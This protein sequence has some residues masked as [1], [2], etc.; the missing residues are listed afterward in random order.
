LRQDVRRAV[1]AVRD[2]KQ[3]LV[4][5]FADEAFIIFEE[6]LT[7]PEMTPD[8]VH[9]VGC[10]G[11]NS[12][13]AHLTSFSIGSMTPAQASLIPSRCRLLFISSACS[14]G[15]QTVTPTRG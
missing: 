13:L 4:N 3:R 15:G 6:C 12:G 1:S 5:L 8:A 10:V 7:A 2:L 14:L 11:E 9:Q